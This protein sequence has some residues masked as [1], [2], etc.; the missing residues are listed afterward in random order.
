M[1]K[2]RFAFYNN[3]NQQSR[4]MEVN[5]EGTEISTEMNGSLNR[6]ISTRRTRNN[7]IVNSSPINEKDQENVNKI[8]EETDAEQYPKD[9]SSTKSTSKKESKL[10]TSTT[11][12][13]AST[14]RSKLGKNN[15][16]LL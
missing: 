13:N 7:N 14:P 10:Q 2:T 11:N 4:N 3:K 1:A 9:E 15:Q 8:R 6:S 16:F 5:E 12:L